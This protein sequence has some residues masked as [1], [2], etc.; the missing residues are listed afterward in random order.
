MFEIWNMICSDLLKNVTRVSTHGLPV[1]SRKYISMN[2]RNKPG[3][4][5]FSVALLEGKR[6]GWWWNDAV[7]G[8]PRS[9]AIPTLFPLTVSEWVFRFVSGSY[10]APGFKGNFLLSKFSLPD[11]ADSRN[12][13]FWEE[14]L[15]TCLF[16]GVRSGSNPRMKIPLATA[17]DALHLSV[18]KRTRARHSSLPCLCGSWFITW[19]SSLMITYKL[20]YFSWPQ[21]LKT[22]PEAAKAEGKK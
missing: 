11:A 7:S 18:L 2:R 1:D 19:L 14:I 9:G 22:K 17:V 5:L 20:A 6:P 15:T 13:T 3:S 21:M 10:A 12:G 8:F 4:R 16:L